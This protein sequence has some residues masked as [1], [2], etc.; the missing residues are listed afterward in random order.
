MKKSAKAKLLKKFESY[1][2]IPQ[3]F[4]YPD[5][6]SL[7]IKPFIKQISNI[8]QPEAQTEKLPG[9][10]LN[11]NFSVQCGP[12][13][14]SSCVKKRVSKLQAAKS[15]STMASLHCNFSSEVNRSPIKSN[16]SR[17][18]LKK[19][20]KLYRF[21]SNKLNA[22]T[23]FRE[24]IQKSIDEY[25]A[26][27]NLPKL[28]ASKGVLR[29]MCLLDK[30]KNA[31]NAAVKVGKKV[32]TGGS[33]YEL[34]TWLFPDEDLEPYKSSYYCPEGRMCKYSLVNKHSRPITSLTAISSRV[35]SGS[36]DGTVKLWS[37]E[38][39]LL[40][41]FHFSKGL[42]SILYLHDNKAVF[43][44]SSIEF[45]DV[46]SGL[47]FHDTVS[48]ESGKVLEKHTNFTFFSAGHSGVVKLWDVRAPRFISKLSEHFDEVTG[49][50]VKNDFE[51]FSCGLD[52]VVKVFDLRRRECVDVQK[53]R[54]GIRGICFDGRFVF[55][56]GEKLVVCDQDCQ[57]V[58]FD[59][60][61][62][63]KW[64]RSVDGMLYCGGTDGVVNIFDTVSLNSNNYS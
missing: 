39:S 44:G 31:V 48:E 1:L 2:K 45:Q 23:G 37:S 35:L 61:K 36:Q 54:E 57:R 29:T 22:R 4:D 53:F 41:I 50:A 18:S 38:E 46:Q 21:K 12:S 24:S 60:E 59:A 13:R 47:A 32:W 58:L 63:V 51:N 10:G 62:S 7:K 30:H 14:Q 8:L 26:G 64:V 34:R 16:I 17:P 11:E 6:R 55:V 28:S 19:V 9:Q 27:V 56:A 15:D 42:K 3:L 33:D 43:G 20:E 49:I 25:F 5:V 52:G 40:K